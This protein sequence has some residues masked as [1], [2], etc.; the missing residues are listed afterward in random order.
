MGVARSQNSSDELACV[1]IE[2]QKRMV[3]VLPEVAV[4]V[5]LFLITVGRIVCG[6]EVQKDLFRSTIFA[7]RSDIQLA[8]SLGDPVAGTGTNRILHP[9]D[10]R[11]ACQILPTLWQD[12]AHQLQQRIGAQ[13]IRIVLVLVNTSYLVDTLSEQRE[14]RVSSSPLSPLRQML[15]H[16][17]THSEFSIHLGQPGKSSV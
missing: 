13:E 1:S 11:L 10:G 7:A 9:A 3:D 5:T 17:L 2:D 4:V 14:H 15:A 6:I 16:R 8:Q 12:S